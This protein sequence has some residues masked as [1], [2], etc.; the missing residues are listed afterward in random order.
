MIGSARRLTGDRVKA[1]GYDARWARRKLERARDH[2]AELT[3]ATAPWVEPVTHPLQIVVGPDRRHVELLLNFAEP[4]PLDEWSLIAGDCI[5]NIRTALD[6]FV[7]ANST[8][9]SEDQRGRVAY[10]ILPAIDD[11]ADADE[12]SDRL[13]DQ[14]RRTRRTAEAKLAGLPEPLRSGVLD[15]LRWA[16]LPTDS[17]VVRHQRLPMIA[18][19]DSADKHRL[20]LDLQ[21]SLSTTTWNV[22]TWGDGG[23]R[24]PVP[25]VSEFTGDLCGGGPWKRIV[26]AEGQSD[27]PIARVEGSATQSVHIRVRLP[28]LRLDA[29]STLDTF[30]R[31]VDGLLDVLGSPV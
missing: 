20:A 11:E 9:L 3:R 13:E 5:H 7:W 6:V 16:S 18:E 10:P 12:V 26:I 1:A 8:E 17:G 2:L 19:L 15:N 30:I 4:P 21:V 28:D 14:P 27:R 24:F 31:D 29:L 22:R 25:L 23:E